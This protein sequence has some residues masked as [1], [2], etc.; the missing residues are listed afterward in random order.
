M[1][2]K[3]FVIEE[4]LYSISCFDMADSAYAD[5]PVRTVSQFFYCFIY[6]S[7]STAVSIS[8]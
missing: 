1:V 5:V 8:G 6:T 2:L 7:M 4:T 3:D